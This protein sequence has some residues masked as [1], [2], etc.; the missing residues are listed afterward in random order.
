MFGVCGWE[1]MRHK[2]NTTKQLPFDRSSGFAGQDLEDA[3][4]DTLRARM[5]A[6]RPLG[7]HWGC[8]FWLHW[9][10]GLIRVVASHDS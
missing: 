1:Q 2:S 7:S 3:A 8:S 4:K 5:V 6:W 10:S 9:F